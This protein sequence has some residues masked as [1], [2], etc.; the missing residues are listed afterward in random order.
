LPNFAEAKLV[1]G[2]MIDIDRREL[3]ALAA[4]EASGNL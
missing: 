1:H 2:Q 4:F 3:S